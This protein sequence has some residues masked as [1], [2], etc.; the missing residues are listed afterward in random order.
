M[1]FAS[2]QPDR[3]R[4]PSALWPSGSRFEK[5]FFLSHTSS[6][7]HKSECQ[8]HADWPIISNRI[9]ASP[10]LAARTLVWQNENP[11]ITRRGF[12]CFTLRLR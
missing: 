11:G 3:A 5:L 1:C 2:A 4:S 9:S 8:Q 6:Q 7:V 12:L 10:I